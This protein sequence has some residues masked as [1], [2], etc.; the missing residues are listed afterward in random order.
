MLA[1]SINYADFAKS[2]STQNVTYII[3]DGTQEVYNI[4]VATYSYRLLAM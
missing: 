4:Y 2:N 3:I 1:A